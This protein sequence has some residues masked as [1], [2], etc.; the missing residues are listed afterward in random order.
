MT[1]SPGTVRVGTSGYQYPHW[2]GV[3]YPPRLPTR[4]WFAYYADHFDTVEINNTF[5]R[6]PDGDVFDSWRQQAPRGFRYAL[7]FSRYGTHIKRLKEP[8]APLERFLDGA[9]RL[10]R[11]LGPVLVQLPPHWRVNVE[12]LSNFVGLLPRVQRWAMELRD[13]S[14]LC[15]DVFDVLTAH[16]V[17]LCVHDMIPDHPRVLTADFVY[18]RFHGDHYRGSYS[19]QFLVAQADRV[20]DYLANEMDCYVYFNNDDQGHAARNA[21]DLK[22]YLATRVSNDGV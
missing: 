14:W 1:V 4:K 3:F 9:E 2:R 13:E 20:A 16:N 17:A 18:L 8:E 6:L 19:H 11:T 15:Q 5:Y 22:R 7:K 12:R 10:G 21:L